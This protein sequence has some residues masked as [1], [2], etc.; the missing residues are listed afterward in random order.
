MSLELEHELANAAPTLL[1]IG[2]AVRSVETS[3]DVVAS[4]SAML[5]VGARHPVMLVRTRTEF[6]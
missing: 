6:V 2:R 3:S 5:G 4:L 1:V